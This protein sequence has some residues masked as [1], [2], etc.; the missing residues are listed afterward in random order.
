MVLEIRN[1]N[2]LNCSAN[3]APT[4]LSIGQCSMLP[5][6]PVTQPPYPIADSSNSFKILALVSA[7]HQ[8]IH[9]SRIPVA[10]L[11]S[12]I[13]FLKHF[14]SIIN[15]RINTRNRFQ[16]H[17]GKTIQKSFDHEI[18]FQIEPLPCH[19]SSIA[20]SSDP[21]KGRFSKYFVRSGKTLR[22]YVVGTM[23]SL[24]RVCDFSKNR[25]LGRNL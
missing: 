9:C 8:M 14:G 13:P 5:A 23:Y 12:H 18:L 17:D 2:A 3:A 10:Q 16:T 21:E 1:S 7:A 15:L 6:S 24:W 19:F 25:I 4:V 22:I 11:S 20:R